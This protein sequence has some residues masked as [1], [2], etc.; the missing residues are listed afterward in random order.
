MTARAARRSS[1]EP[2]KWNG[3]VRIDSAA[4]PPR[5]YA[6]TIS[7]TVEPSRIAPADGERRLCSA[8]SEMPGPQQRLRERPPL[9]ALGDRG[10]EPGE[11]HALAAPA[12]LVARVLDDPLEHAHAGAS[13]L[14]MS[15]SRSSAAAARPSSIAASAARTPSSS[16]STRPAT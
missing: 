6:C 2:P 7:S 5:S 10:L 8:I 4:A 9:G 3:S 12:D 16:D 15:T 11:R 14:V 1:S 13:S